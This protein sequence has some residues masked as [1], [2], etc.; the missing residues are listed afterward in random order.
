MDAYDNPFDRLNA[1]VTA[2]LGEEETVEIFVP[3]EMSPDFTLSNLKH[4]HVDAS[5][6]ADKIDEEKYSKANSIS[7]CLTVTELRSKNILTE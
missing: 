2:M 7:K 4:E 6:T 1:L 3:V 5:R